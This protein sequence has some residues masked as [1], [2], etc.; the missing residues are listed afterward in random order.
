MYV[1]LLEHFQYPLPFQLKK[2]DKL[3]CGYWSLEQT[4]NNLFDE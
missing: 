1:C 3:D 2:V 4:K